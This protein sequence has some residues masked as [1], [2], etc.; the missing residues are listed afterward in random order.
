MI[1]S[2]VVTGKFKLILTYN[3]LY[4]HDT[5][6]LHLKNLTEVHFHLSF[7]GHCDIF[8]HIFYL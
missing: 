7:L 4:S 5:K 2:L 1:F 8:F 6:L 3:N